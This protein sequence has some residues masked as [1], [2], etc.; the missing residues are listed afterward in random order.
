MLELYS[1]CGLWK[2]K[3]NIK[4]EFEIDD[5]SGV[6]LISIDEGTS[7]SDLVKIL[8]EDFAIDNQKHSLK[9]SFQ[10]P[11]MT[12]TLGSHP[13]FIR[14]DRQLATFMRISAQ[15]QSIHLCVTVEDNCVIVEQD[16][17]SSYQFV[18][19][20]VT[21]ASHSQVPTML[22][23]PAATSGLFTSTEDQTSSYQ[24]VASDVSSASHSQVP[25]MPNPFAATAGLF[26][27][28]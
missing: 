20:D 13:I 26:T 14:N 23:P 27:S 24:F 5:E 12:A 6:S 21:S 9:L 25:T 19:S 3:H 18:A 1:V 8:Y 11:S 22:N 15:T 28:A 16:Q 7:F 10:L 2:L 4:W 17:T